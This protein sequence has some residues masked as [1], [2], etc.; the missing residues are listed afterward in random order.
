MVVPAAVAHLDEFEHV[1]GA[2][3]LSLLQPDHLNLLLPV[4]KNT[5]LRL[6]VQEV[7]HL[8]HMNFHYSCE[9]W[10]W[11]PAVEI[12]ERTPEVEVLKWTE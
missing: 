10:N 12:K 5:Q 4:F 2:F 11:P 6:P 3:D 7:K 8:Q 9:L 1:L